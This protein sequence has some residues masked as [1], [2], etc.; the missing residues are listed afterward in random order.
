MFH[1]TEELDYRRDI[2]ALPDT[3]VAHLIADVKRTYGRLVREWLRYMRYLK[4]HY[5]YLYSLA[6]RTNPFDPQA[7]PIVK[8]Q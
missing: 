5:P 7:T 1:L 6:V 2:Q 4:G 8:T 3:D